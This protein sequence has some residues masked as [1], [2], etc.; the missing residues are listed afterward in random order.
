MTRYY[1]DVWEDGRLSVDAE[2]TELHDIEAARLE[3]TLA[4]AELARD[5][6]PGTRS[7]EITMTVRDQRE[8]P[9]FM[10]ELRFRTVF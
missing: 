5:A 9:R 10:L 8:G 4:L 1:F 6:L 7:K 2:G 3:A